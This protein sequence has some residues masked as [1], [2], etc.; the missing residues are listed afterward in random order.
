MQKSKT[1]LGLDLGVASIGWSL[2]RSED[3]FPNQI[4]DMGVRI[5]PLTT[6]ETDEFTKGNAISKNR[7]RTMMRTQRKGLD[8]YQLRR[9]ALIACLKEHGMMPDKKMLLHLSPLE[10]WGLRA[11]A[12][13]NEITLEELG[14]VLL[15]L[16]QKRGYKHSKSDQS[17]DEKK[18]TDYVAAVNSRFD[19]IRSKGWT[20]GEL[21]YKGLKDFE[22][23]QKEWDE[24][25]NEPVF[26]TKEKVFPRAAYEAEFDQVWNVQKIF[27]PAALTDELYEEIRNE[28]IYYQ[29][30]LKSQ[31]GLVSIC[32]FERKKY[33]TNEGKEI[34][35][36][37]KVAPRSS[38]LFQVCKLWESINNITIKNRRGELF[39]LTPEHK[40]EIFD[41]LQI[42][43]WL[44][45]NELFK[46][47]G[48]GR[49]AGYF[50]NEQIR[51]K[52]IQGNTTKAAILSIVGKDHPC[53]QFD[54]E[55][56]ASALDRSTGELKP[57]V[58]A[59]FE[60]E[61]LYM[62]WHVIYSLNNN[63]AD[64]INTLKSSFGFDDDTAKKLASLDFT[65]G[66]FGNKSAKAI[67]K[68]LPYLQ[69]GKMYSEACALAGY[70]HSN[71]LTKEE[72]LNREL[73]EK[74]EPLKKNSLRQPVVEK[75]LNQ[76]INLVNALMEKHGRPDEIR[77]ELARELKQSREERNN[78][79][80]NINKRERDNDKIRKMLLEDPA[81]KKKSVSKRDI[82]RYRLWEELGK[83]SP[84]EP[85]KVI[86]LGELFNGNYDIEHIVPRSLRF[87]D[88]FGN[89]T[90][91]PRKYNS[92]EEGKNAMTAF[93]YMLT[94]K[95]A[96][97]F[98]AYIEFIE[99]AY[100]DKKITKT[101]YENLLVSA[102]K[103]TEGFI[104]RQLRET[105]YI[106]KKA[107]DILK[108][109]CHEVHTTTGTV[110]QRLRELWGWDEVLENLNLPKYKSLGLTEMKEINHKGQLS[111]KEKIKD[112][113]KRDDHRHHAIDALVIACTSQAVIHRLNSLNA[114]QT[115]DE[116]FNEIKERKDK[117]YSMLD[118]YL[119]QLKPFETSEIAEKA[120][121]IL[122]SFK[123]G[124][125]VATLSRR[126][127]KKGGKKV[128]VQKQIIE[129]RGP[130]S[131]ESVYGKIKKKTIKKVKLDKNFSDVEN[132]IDEQLRTI[133]CDRLKAYDN[134]L[135]RAFG[136][137]K[138]EPVWRD[139]EKTLAVTDVEVRVLVEEFVLRYPVASITPD[140][141]K[142]IVDDKVREVVA[143]RLAAFGNNPKE[144]YKDLVR[145]PIWL[146]KEKG[147]SVKKV[148]RYTGI[149]PDSIAAIKVKDESWNIE[150]E[151][152]VKTGSNHHIAIYR[153][154]N[155]KLAEHVV[156]F[157]HAVERKKYGVPVIIKDTAALWT[158]ILHR[159]LSQEF[160]TELPNDN[161]TYVTSMQQNE[162]FVF[163]M[164]EAEL[165]SAIDS[166][167]YDLIAPNIFRV[168][169]ISSGAYWFNQQYE[170]EPRESLNDKK[171]ARC[172]QRSLS[173][174][175][176]I[177]VK[178]NSVGEI[179]IAEKVEESLA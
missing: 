98:E 21:F 115:K 8:R 126:L 123:P 135:A 178:V 28:I 76:L 118:N 132:V 99:K 105:Q 33:I 108:D 41:R 90:I 88:S 51:K 32:E 66:G 119:L 4:I 133:L 26:R 96:A 58:S 87:D 174:M 116:I 40:Q 56:N 121:R 70:D 129:P 82:E 64:C 53:L 1:I 85:G 89:K 143:A 11:K 17:E 55:I 141:L 159:E 14:R 109:I 54:L 101:K 169:K 104:E 7:S 67:R 106:A 112:W 80:N 63:E 102:D 125:K 10:I 165:Q 122:I 50:A 120:A 140:H 134:D 130:L 155:G 72:N 29:R 93:D 167:R 152:Y 150:Y 160:L 34:E 43:E 81:F 94:R 131:E 111:L 69:E 144:A 36:G 73:K 145:N 42:N 157:W 37:P 136:N 113:T 114:Q 57:A 15:H 83:I 13:K 27:H 162:T 91:C 171:A 18:Q 20:I 65:K 147:I 49:N 173:S 139:T 22:G 172:I 47:L 97:E 19:F 84:Y 142:S 24:A 156:S 12:A 95:S 5:I 77:V 61:P 52:G 176:G 68:L 137:L 45:L 79:Y 168:R 124:K 166:K 48:L 35:A 46:I 74:L 110:T 60:K 177:K 78:A 2:I 138:K 128:P 158:S 164:P 25:A 31:K 163:N 9:K 59:E 153:D 148:R 23:L 179:F 6:D 71:S 107:K 175:E 154:E 117:K 151:K 127:V 30:R 103:L 3:N 161:W 170:T 86:G 16:N 62:L 92:G 146:N 44:K 75:I 100:S 38:P 39:E 149:K